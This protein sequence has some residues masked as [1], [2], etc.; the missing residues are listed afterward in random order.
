MEKEPLDCTHVPAEKVMN[1][2]IQGTIIWMPLDRYEKFL[3]YID[4]I[5][6]LAHE[7]E[8]HWIGKIKGV[9]IKRTIT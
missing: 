8:T 5:G 3:A 1:Y 2:Y 7:G 6:P 4:K 9:T